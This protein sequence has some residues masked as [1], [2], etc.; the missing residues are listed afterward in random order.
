MASAVIDINDTEMKIKI[1]NLGCPTR[2]NGVDIT[3][4]TDCIKI[5]NETYINKILE[6]HTWMKMEESFIANKPIP[7]NSDKKYLQM[8]EEAQ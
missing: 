4:S 8:I 3:Q 2:Y 1:K 6:G 5:H 7:M